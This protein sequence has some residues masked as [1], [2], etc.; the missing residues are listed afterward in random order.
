M[1]SRGIVLSDRY[2]LDERVATGGM[3]DV[4]LGTDVLLRRKVAVKVLLPALVSDAEFITRFRTEARMMAALRHPGIVQIYDYG[5]DAVVDGRRVDY[6]V[7][8]YI[9]GV[10]LS[11]W[12]RETAEL[13]VGQAMS[14]VT[15]AAQAL[16]VAHT[17]GIV[18]RDVK[19]SNLLVQPD[20]SVVLVDFGVARSANLTSITATNMVL[21]SAHYMAP[22]QAAGQPVSAATDIYALGAVAY[23][24]LTGRPPFTGDNPIEV[25]TRHLQEEP[26]ALPEEI[27]APVAALVSRALA[28]APADRY[29]SAAAFAD[30]AR[31]AQGT[32][33]LPTPIGV[34]DNSTTVPSAPRADPSPVAASVGGKRRRP[35]L[36]GGVAAAVVIGAI[37]LVALLS[38]PSDED[39]SP[40]Q[41]VAN[42]P[43]EA[44]AL[45]ADPAPP[46]V[47]AQAASSKPSPP[48][49]TPGK[50]GAPVTAPPTSAPTTAAGPKPSAKTTQA[51]AAAN[52]HTPGEVCGSGYQVVDSAPLTGTNGTQYGKVYLL[53][54]NGNG[55][56]CT[57]TMKTTSV[58]TG[59]AVS[60]YLEVQGRPRSTDSGSFAYYAGP[61]R[62]HA[63][64]TCVRWGGSAG[65]ASYDSPFEHC[66]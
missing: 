29:P 52:P 26:P 42:V 53:Y 34:A 15:Q 54:N 25:V 48:P 37:G 60:A 9:E 51:P 5:E 39:P 62:A 17:A 28:K 7:M 63:A 57:V 47:P 8:E 22:E 64:G 31:A 14:I 24:C 40:T 3:G 45:G 18:H 12:I 33:P 10:P 38:G 23:C 35:I 2:Q 41:P 61:V 11:T 19:P 65:G 13:D 43:V 50:P 59:S 21:G 4:W 1:L 30:A 27:P 32:A 36:L 16:H 44:P 6:L 20:G 49:V 55:Y 66:G 46:V 56:N 58:G